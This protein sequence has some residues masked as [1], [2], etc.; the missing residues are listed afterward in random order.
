VGAYLVLPGD[1]YDDYSP[2]DHGCG[3]GCVLPALADTQLRRLV[4]HRP[5]SGGVLN[6]AVNWLERRHRLIKRSLAIL[7]TYLVLAC[8]SSCWSTS[9][10]P[11]PGRSR[12]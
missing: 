12:S 5:L 10:C 3:V 9:A 6:P 1:A 7:L 2:L 11:V 4:R 8:S